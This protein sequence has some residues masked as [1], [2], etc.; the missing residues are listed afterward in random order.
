MKK[1]FEYQYN[2]QVDPDYKVGSA[3]QPIANVYQ[4]MQSVFAYIKEIYDQ[5]RV[6]K[7]IEAA[8]GPESGYA[9]LIKPIVPQIDPTELEEW[10][11]D[12]N[13][14]ELIN[15]PS[16]EVVYFD[17]PEDYELILDSFCQ[18]MGYDR[19]RYSTNGPGSVKM[20]VQHPGQMFPLHFDRPRHS[21][22]QPD[23]NSLTRLPSHQRH[24]IFIED[25]QP[26]QLFQMD[27]DLLHWRA[28]DVFTWD[29]RNTMHGT[30]NVGYWPRYMLMI[31]LKIEP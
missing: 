24:L 21:D 14:H 4:E 25:Q 17:C 26:G 6:S 23:K 11:Y 7:H 12:K 2:N 22:L 13:F 28:G 5:P 9:D 29:A 18:C 19:S 31:T 10:I 20:H 16:N 30:A 15:R 3:T 8:F 27:Y 1:W